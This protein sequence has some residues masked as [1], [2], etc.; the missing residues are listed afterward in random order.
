MNEPTPNNSA[1][2]G[3]DRTYD[4]G[5]VRLFVWATVLWGVSGLGVGL[6][7][8]FQMAIPALNVLPELSF[9]RLRPVHTN[10]AVFAFAGNAIFAA[11]YYSTQRLCAVRMWHD[12]LSR[13]HFWG[14]QAVVLAGFVTLPFGVTQGKPLAEVEWPIDLLAALVWIVF[15]GL[16]VLQTIRLRR[17]DRMSPSL[18]FYLATVVLV[19]VVHVVN[20]LAWPIGFW[21]FVETGELAPWSTVARSYP[22]TAGVQDAFVQWWF[23][24]NMVSAFL[25]MPFMGAMYYFLP[26]ATGR[27]VYSYRLAALHFWSVV[28]VGVWAGRSH[29]H[30]TPLPGWASA[31]GVV[32]AVFLLLA[33]VAG[34]MNLLLT[35]GRGWRAAL[36]EP[37]A[38]FLTVGVVLFAISAVEQALLSF[39]SVDAFAHFTD[40]AIGQVHGATLGWNGFVIFGVLYWVLPRVF[41]SEDEPEV[42]RPGLVRAH[43]WL[44]TLGI[45][46]YV[47]AMHGS[48]LVQASMLGGVTSQGALATPDFLDAVGA[49]VPWY[50]VRAVGGALYVLG[51]ALACVN[52]FLTWRAGRDFR[53]PCGVPSDASVSAEAVS[54]PVPE[55]RLDA[56]I[57]LG[58]AGDRLLQGAW[59][60]RLERRPLRF[61]LLILAGFGTVSLLG[62]LPFVLRPSV[63]PAG[64]ASG[65]VLVARPYT[66]LELRGRDLYVSEG[67]LQCHSQVVRP[68]FADAVRYGDVSRAGE[69]MYDRPML[70]GS[71]RIGPDLSRV[72]LSR[73]AS[74]LYRHLDEPRRSRPGTIMPSYRHLIERRLDFSGV[75]ARVNASSTLGVPVVGGSD[76]SAS[77][78]SQASEIA[79]AIET[80]EGVPASEIED[81]QVVA[82][83]AYLQRL[84]SSIRVPV[85]EGDR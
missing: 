84:G 21:H 42:A 15:F 5:I 37:A 4:D 80:R 53:M 81:R 11:V 26:K 78:R 9:G 70:W 56:N 73:D 25:V 74:W 61:S 47:G 51:M 16:N 32:S 44:A 77:A 57:G 72:G 29:L 54:E 67:C 85:P 39:R 64:G 38:R 82:L 55:S 41:G 52:V 33:N 8:A 10:A 60:R 63:A 66:P 50:W 12:G 46:L 24:H 48:G 23:G 18:W 35:V 7:L 83:I 30:L 3:V 14:W 49:S 28:L 43:F 79:L 2:P 36:S 27:P 20:N 69:S 62:F 34:V 19:G 45:V 58:H 6:L 22:A 75:A 71:R 40:L 59:H 1:G 17:V 68:L 65:T 13:L 31:V 76:V